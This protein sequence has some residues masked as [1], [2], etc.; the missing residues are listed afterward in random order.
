MFDLRRAY[1]ITSTQARLLIELLN[2]RS[3]KITEIENDLRL[4]TDAKVA[5][6]KLRQRLAGSG[7]DIRT[8]RGAGYFLDPETKERV[9]NKI[10]LLAEAA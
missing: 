2:N 7:I 4:F 3:V 5:M 1:R 8:L 9:R 10:R 6:H